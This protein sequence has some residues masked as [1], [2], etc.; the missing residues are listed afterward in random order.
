MKYSSQFFS[1][2]FAWTVFTNTSA[3]A[4][5]CGA[6]EYVGPNGDCQ[7][8]TGS[9][10]SYNPFRV[11][12]TCGNGTF[13]TCQPYAYKVQ[14]NT[15]E[16]VCMPCPKISNSRTLNIS[17]NYS[18]SQSNFYSYTWSSSGRCNMLVNMS[19]NNGCAYTATVHPSAACATS[20]FKAYSDVALPKRNMIGEDVSADDAEQ[21]CDWEITNKSAV[22]APVNYGWSRVSGA[23]ITCSQCGSSKYSPADSRLC[24]DLP[25]NAYQ[26]STNNDGYSCGNNTYKGE[27]PYLESVR[28]IGCPIYGDFNWDD[29][30][31]GNAPDGAT[32][33]NA[34]YLPVGGGGMSGSDA[35]GNW[36]QVTSCPLTGGGID[37][38]FV[39]VENGSSDCWGCIMNICEDYYDAEEEGIRYCMDAFAQGVAVDTMALRQIMM[40][41]ECEID[42]DID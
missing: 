6:N 24:I 23:N 3:F 1:L 26:D 22:S 38:V 28:C 13:Y 14:F 19:T 11:S 40:C 33:V 20:V 36:V 25:P 34:C 5:T 7:S 35:T 42:V 41:D 27:D 17:N 12:G 18:I 32:S 2:I 4:T 39:T 30:V 15:T 16:Y 10:T 9:N 8:C 21:G 37:D 29:T 31:F